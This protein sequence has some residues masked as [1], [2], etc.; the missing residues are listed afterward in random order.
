MVH[1]AQCNQGSKGEFF[2]ALPADSNCLEGGSEA[3]MRIC[4]FL[5]N[6]NQVTNLAK[7][8][9]LLLAKDCRE[10]SS[11]VGKVCHGELTGPSLVS[12]ASFAIDWW[13]PNLTRVT[14]HLWPLLPSVAQCHHL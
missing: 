6:G 1:V 2:S 9:L 10:G 8:V 4:P 11:L 12:D 3:N 13:L 5:G 7:P 14:A